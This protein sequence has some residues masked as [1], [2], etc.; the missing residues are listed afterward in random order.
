VESI[1]FTESWNLED[2]ETILNKWKEQ[3]QKCGVL[4]LL[5][6]AD[7][8][9]AKALQKLFTQK[10]IPLAGAVFPTLL[11]DNHFYKNGLVL[12]PF[13]EMPYYAFLSMP[14]NHQ[15]HAKGLADEITAAVK[16]HLE[17]EV[18]TTL[19]LIF[20]AMIPDI[21][22]IL[23]ELYLILA[24]RVHYM[25]V[26]AGSETFK[27]M[28]CL[29]DN[30]RIFQDGVLV[31]LLKHHAGAILEHGYRAPSQMI[32]ATATKGNRII[33]IDWRP[34]FEVYREMAQT[35]YN[36]VI[37]KDNFYQYAVHFPFGILRANGEIIVRIPVALEEDGSL[38]CVG[39][40]PANSVLTL[41]N[42]P[43]VDLA[44]TIKTLA[45]GLTALAGSTKEKN[46]VTFYCAGRRLHIGDKAGEELQTLAGHTQANRIVGA[47]SLG[48]IGSSIQGGY[49]LFHNATIVC[50]F[51]EDQ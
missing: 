43:E 42:A 1:Y 32:S 15:N 48:E 4:A 34:A 31:I 17:P 45:E 25:G 27:P 36:I 33:S 47:L 44:K 6:E 11:A 28:P 35:H 21:S 19:F 30:S 26:N 9:N 24:D 2:I 14:G 10:N 49:P 41:L 38:F 8:D 37:N 13:H 20:D 22:T 46:L 7:K 40:V 5:P 50:T 29:F 18:E 39:E 23:D 12:L 16:S 51:W 3:W